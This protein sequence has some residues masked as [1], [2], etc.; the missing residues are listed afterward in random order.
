MGF[1][2][3]WRGLRDALPNLAL[4][5]PGLGGGQVRTMDEDLLAGTEWRLTG[6]GDPARPDRA[7]G[8]PT[9]R[10]T[11]WGELSGRS[12]CGSYR[13]G[14]TLG[15]GELRVENLTFTGAAGRP[16]PALLEQEGRFRDVL[17]RPEML[18]LAGERLTMTGGSGEALIFQRVE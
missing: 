3:R 6:L 13:A 10:F 8:N 4:P 12:G 2:E 7:S 17:E 1:G 18:E 14:Y 9:I 15:D 16:D 11:T 5:A